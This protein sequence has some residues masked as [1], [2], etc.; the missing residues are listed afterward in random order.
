MNIVKDL[1]SCPLLWAVI[2]SLGVSGVP[3]AH[4]QESKPLS[5]KIIRQVVEVVVPAI[6]SGNEI[7]FLLSLIHI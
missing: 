6:K 5:K 3:Q 4:G 7:A 2:L 1:L